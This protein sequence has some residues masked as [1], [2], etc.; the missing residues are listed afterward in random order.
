MV[1]SYEEVKAAMAAVVEKQ[2]EFNERVTKDWVISGNPYWRALAQ[3]AAKAVGHLAWPWWS[4]AGRPLIPD[5]TARF[6]LYL[7]LADCLAFGVSA[8][9]ARGGNAYDRFSLSETTASE[10]TENFLAEIAF[11]HEGEELIFALEQ[12]QAT[13]LVTRRFNANALFIAA[14]ASGLGF[15]GL[16][17]IYHG[18]TIL[19]HFR[20]EHGYKEGTY[21]KTWSFEG[22]DVEDNVVLASII[23]GWLAMHPQFP[24][25][26]LLSESFR[27]YVKSNLAI[28]Y[29]QPG[30]DDADSRGDLGY[31]RRATD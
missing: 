15:S 13:A 2:F 10:L 30:D 1:H 25:E 17:A 3:E 29:R 11:L 9:M 28:G 6:Q 16:L 23:N 4:K 24:L 18:K 20:Q 26:R 14:S 5:D 21:R 7:E 22:R 27:S 8:M 19:N 12:V 31:R